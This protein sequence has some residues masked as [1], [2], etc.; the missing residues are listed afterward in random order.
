MGSTGVGGSLS[1]ASDVNLSSP[2]T[3]E[4]LRRSGA[5]WTNSALGKA[6]IGLANVDNTSD[7]NKPVSLVT[8]TALNTKVTEILWT[9]S[10]WPAIPAGATFALRFVSTNDPNA[11]EPPT[12]GRLIGMI[13]K[14]HPNAM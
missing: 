8:Q 4:S 11:T 1:A 14:K 7:T 9:G 12:A 10:A 2:A 13:W 3:G 6:D 5:H